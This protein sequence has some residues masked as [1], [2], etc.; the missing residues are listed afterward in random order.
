MFEAFK[1]GF[2]DIQPE[3][4]PSAWTSSYDFPAVT[5]G[6]VVKEVF[7]TGLPKGMQGF[8]FNTRRPIFSDIRVRKA[9]AKTL[10]FDWINKNLYFGAFVRSDGYFNDSEL[11]S[12]GKPAGE[13]EKALLAP[14][15]NVV[16]GDV[17]SGTYKAVAAN[18]A[19][20]DRKILR[21]VVDEMKA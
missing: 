7:K 13:K 15:P 21:Q 6:R 2:Y 5:D 4:D 1:K 11:S 18:V 20:G 16:S 19:A 12:I 14:F 17:M 3:G 9:L 10:D 8:A